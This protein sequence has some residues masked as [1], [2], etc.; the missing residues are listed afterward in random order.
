MKIFGLCGAF[1]V[2]FCLTGV[3]PAAA[4][5]VLPLWTQGAPE[6]AGDVG[7]EHDATKP[8]DKLVGGRRI[9]ALASVSVPTLTLYRAD[10]AGKRPA[11]LVFPGGGYGILAYDLEGT[12]VCAWLNS[13]QVTCVLVKYRVPFK[14]HYP[15]R[16]EDLE[17]AQQAMRLTRMHAEEWGIDPKR[18]GVVGFSAGGHLAA[19]LS[20]HFDFVPT[21]N[22]VRE[23]GGVDPT[24]SARPDFAMLIY[25]AYLE[26]WPD[27]SKVAPEVLPT[28][29]TPPT[30]LLQAEDDP[31]HEENSLVYFQ[32]LKSAKVE[33]ELHLYAKGG[34][35]YGLRPVPNDPITLWPAL[36]ETWLRTIRVLEAR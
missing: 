19:V 9:I 24:V 32:A 4:Q 36:A 29:A 13:I 27:I 8:T 12:E 17:D 2:G 21:G 3:A 5:M 33:A 31:V 15:E 10:G 30:F 7:P 23:H 14:G 35:G 26:P 1:V 11:A 20:N 18:V 28:A 6:P 34:H 16:S 22:A 25:P